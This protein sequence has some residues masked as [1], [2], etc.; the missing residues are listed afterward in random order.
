MTEF[1]I[2]FA[3]PLTA[4]A[5]TYCSLAFLAGYASLALVLMRGRLPKSW[6]EVGRPGRMTNNPALV[7]LRGRYP[8]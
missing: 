8:N 2:I 7:Q 3:D 1:D 4:M 6:F 5:Y